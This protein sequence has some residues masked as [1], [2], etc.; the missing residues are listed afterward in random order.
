MNRL[1]AIQKI[2]DKIKANTY[3]EIGVRD[4][5]VIN[6]VRAPYMYGIDPCFSLSRNDKVKKIF[7]LLNFKAI[8]LTSDEFFEKQLPSRIQKYGID[9]AFVDGLHTY[10]QALKDVEN[11]LKHLNENGFIIMHDCNPIS[12]AGAYPMKE[13]FSEIEEYIRKEKPE[14]W[15]WNWNGDVWKALVHLRITHDDLQIFTV[16]ADWGLGIVKK[17]PSEKLQNLTVEQL[18]EANYS[19]LEQ[20]RK[21]LLNLKEPSYFLDFIQSL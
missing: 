16:D 7:H 2:I 11:S 3:V 15:N 10:Q 21:E 9:V 12:A 4:G 5:A 14:G 18:K 20:D 1:I 17:G 6:K 19:L 13:S 8:D